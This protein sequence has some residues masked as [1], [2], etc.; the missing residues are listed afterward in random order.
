MVIVNCE[1]FSSERLY[2]DALK[3]TQCPFFVVP[4]AVTDGLSSVLLNEIVPEL[5]KMLPNQPSAEELKADSLLHRFVIV[6]APEGS[7]Y[8]LPSALREKRIGVI[9]S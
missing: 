5:L 6:F 4:K 8:S 1:H 2:S 7:T 9:K 3:K